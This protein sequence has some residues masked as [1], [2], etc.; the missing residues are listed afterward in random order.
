V[1]HVPYVRLKSEDVLEDAGIWGWASA[2]PE[3][4]EALGLGTGRSL[5]MP[6]AGPRGERRGSDRRQ[7][8]EGMATL[9]ATEPSHPDRT[10]YLEALGLCDPGFERW[11][12]RRIARAF[13]CEKPESALRHA[14]AAVNVRPGRAEARFNLG[15][16]L[17]RIAS[18]APGSPDAR[19]WAVLARGEFARAAALSPELFW[20]YYHRGV[21]A[22]EASL[23][24]A[25]RADWLQFLDCYVADKPAP[26]DAHLRLLPLDACPESAEIPGL[27]YAVLLD[28]LGLPAPKPAREPAPN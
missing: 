16:V 10:L 15:L 21:L 17:T 12:S 4:I 18:R 2:S 25:A 13:A 9:L 8:R 1:V 28:L 27:A 11:L 3:L 24:D 26:R 20:G 7:I 22:Y 5:E 23:P 14:V 19:R 6:L